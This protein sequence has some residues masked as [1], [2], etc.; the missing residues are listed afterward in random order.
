MTTQERVLSRLRIASPHAVTKAMFSPLS[1]RTVEAT[2]RELR[3]A[4]HPIASDA[5][6]YW[7]TSSPAEL[8]ATA[9]GLLRRMG[10]VAETRSALLEKAAAMEL[11]GIGAE[12]PSIWDQP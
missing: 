7:I 9:D 8:R 5:S 2:I 6:G 1:P 4:G 12:A 3:L 10:H 11:A